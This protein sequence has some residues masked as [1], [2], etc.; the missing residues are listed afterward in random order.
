MSGRRGPYVRT[1]RPGTRAICACGLS[2][3]LP[4][5]DGAHLGTGIEP[6]MVDLAEERTVMWCGCGR[7]KGRPF[8]DG[9]HSVEP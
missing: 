9:S 8:C 5:C 6:F 4:Y 1:E 3:M 2:T 7:S